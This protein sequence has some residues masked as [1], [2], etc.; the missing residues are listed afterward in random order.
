MSDSIKGPTSN[1]TM[2]TNC[3]N[4]SLII[5]NCLIINTTGVCFSKHNVYVLTSS[6]QT[7]LLSEQSH[8]F[9]KLTEIHHIFKF[10]LTKCATV[11]IAGSD[12][13]LH[14]CATVASH[15]ISWSQWSPAWKYP[16]P[17]IFITCIFKSCC[18]SMILCVDK[19][20][21]S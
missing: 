13:W 17:P 11:N 3:F 8:T 16:H 12:Y 19:R 15:N 21:S 1:L 5:V 10:V 6:F 18:H 14:F 9:S 2:N 7:I 4:A 20:H